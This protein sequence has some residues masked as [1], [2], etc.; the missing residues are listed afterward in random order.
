[1]LFKGRISNALKWAFIAWLIGVLPLTALCGVFT[2]YV[3]HWKPNDAGTYAAA[4]IVDIG[5][6][7]LVL[8]ACGWYKFRKPLPPPDDE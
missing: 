5:I 6:Y 1:M 2:Y 3:F 8:L 4:V 7:P